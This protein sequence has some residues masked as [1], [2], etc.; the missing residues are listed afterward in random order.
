[1]GRRVILYVLSALLAEIKIMFRLIVLVS[2]T[3]ALS[4]FHRPL[5]RLMRKALYIFVAAVAGM[6]M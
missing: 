6:E 3:R 2:L 4:A 5:S 1:M